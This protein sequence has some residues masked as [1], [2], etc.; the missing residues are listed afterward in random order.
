MVLCGTVANT[1]TTSSQLSVLFRNEVCVQYILSQLC[2]TLLSEPATNREVHPNEQ[3]SLTWQ[4]RQTAERDQR[5]KSTTGEGAFSRSP[6]HS[7]QRRPTK[8]FPTRGTNLAFNTLKNWCAFSLLR[9]VFLFLHLS[10]CLQILSCLCLCFRA[11]V[12]VSF[13]L[14]RISR[15]LPYCCLASSATKWRLCDAGHA[16][17]VTFNRY[18]CN[19]QVVGWRGEERWY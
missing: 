14:F 19:W 10:V 6:S 12:R 9:S 11:S 17:L 18:W 1:W 13:C 15:V 5:Q 2:I 16:L 8:R 3:M 4:R 7:D